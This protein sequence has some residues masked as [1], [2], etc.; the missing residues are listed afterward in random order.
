MVRRYYFGAD[1]IKIVDN[2]GKMLNCIYAY[3]D[4]RS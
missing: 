2:I 4:E 1:Q 3:K